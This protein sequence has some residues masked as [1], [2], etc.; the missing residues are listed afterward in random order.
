MSE[1][2]SSEIIIYLRNAL[3]IFVVYYLIYRSLLVIKGTRAAPMLGG[4]TVI[5]VLYFLSKP[6]GFLTLGWL[7]GNFLSSIILVVVI[8][9]QDEI[10][11]G[12]TKVGLQPIFHKTDKTVYDK[13]IE[14]ITLVVTKLSKSKIGAL[15]VVQREIGLDEIVEEAVILD[16]LLNR[17]LL[18]SLFV[19]ESPLHDGAVLIDGDRI[20]AAGCVLPLSFNPD[21]DPNLGTRHRAALGLSERTDAIVIVV[22][23]ENGSVSLAREGRM[24]R[25]LDASMLRDSLHRLLSTKASPAQ[26]PEEI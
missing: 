16:A 21:L 23:E 5:V 11:R 8:I 14:D 12:L 22:S 6:F 3:D 15:I 7:L 24:V 9:F 17:K 2:G 26:S 25:N 10:R 4:L 20:R 18:I 13:T 19:K 1:I